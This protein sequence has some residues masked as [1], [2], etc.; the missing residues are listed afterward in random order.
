[1]EAARAS[2][3][4]VPAVHEVTTVLGRPG[5]VMERIEGPDLLTLVGQRPWTIFRVGRISGEVHAQM[6][7]VD[8]PSG[9]PPLRPRLKERIESLSELPQ[10]LSDFALDALDGLPDGDRLCHGDFHPANMLMAGETPVVIDW[11]A[12]TRGDPIA[13][14]ARTWLTLRLGEVPPGTAAML[15][16]LALVGRRILV[17]LYLRSYRRQRPLDMHLLTRWEVPIAAGR[18]ADGIKSE[19]PALVKL[20]EERHAEARA[21]PG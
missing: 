3:V 18:L 1:M 16:L 17:G 20:L 15:R 4:R 13:D 8:A 10:H 7:A 14:V 2:G 9:I 11:T 12:A 5:L 19:E 6:H 21:S